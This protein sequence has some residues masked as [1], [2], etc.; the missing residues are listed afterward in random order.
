MSRLHCVLHLQAGCAHC[1]GR[2]TRGCMK[3]AFRYSFGRSTNPARGFI[4]QICASRYSGVRSKISKCTFATAACAKMYET[5]QRR[6]RQPAAYESQ[7]FTTFLH[8][9]PARSDEIVAIC[10]SQ[11]FWTSDV[12]F[13]REG[14]LRR[15]KN[16][17]SASDVDFCVKGCFDT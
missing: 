14:L 16:L 11:Q 13:L 15:V 9:R 12:H 2:F 7:H 4:Q 10:V 6:P 17:L 1:T 5:Y 8:V 3:F